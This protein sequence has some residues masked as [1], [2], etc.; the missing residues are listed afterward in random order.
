MDK[1]LVAIY[2]NDILVQHYDDKII[3]EAA[4]APPGLKA[5]IGRHPFGD[6]YLLQGSSGASSIFFSAF[7]ATLWGRERSSIRLTD[8]SGTC[9]DKWTGVTLL[10]AKAAAAMG[11]G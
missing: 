8:R 2:G 10:S 11:S 1:F 6:G 9:T 3:R 5:G 4:R 7:M